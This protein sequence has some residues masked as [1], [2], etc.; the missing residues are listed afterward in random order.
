MSLGYDNAEMLMVALRAYIEAAQ[1]EHKARESFQGSS[2][3]Y[4]GQ[5]HIQARDNAAEAFTKRLNDYIDAR[6]AKA[7]AELDKAQP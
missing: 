4:Y 1:D 6:V 7:I 3:D 5:Y 2:W